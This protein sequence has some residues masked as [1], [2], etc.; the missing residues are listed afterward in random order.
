MVFCLLCLVVFGFGVLAPPF[1]Y[2]ALLFIF[3][4][5]ESSGGIRWHRVVASSELLKKG[6]ES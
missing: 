6:K 3:N 4:V 2:N 1:A 5:L